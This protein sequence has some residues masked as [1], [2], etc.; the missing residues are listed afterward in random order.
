MKAICKVRA[1]ETAQIFG[2][3]YGVSAIVSLVPEQKWYVQKS[4]GYYYV[5][6]NGGIKLRLT[7]TAFNKLFKIEEAQND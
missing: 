2:D 6:R 5:W 4:N 3:M 1:T 7:P